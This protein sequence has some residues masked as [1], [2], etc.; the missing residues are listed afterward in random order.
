MPVAD[1]VS[2]AERAGVASST[3]GI[4]YS[5]SGSAYVAEGLQSARSSLKHNALPHVLFSSED[6][7]SVD[8]VAIKR[9]QASTEPF[10]DKIA[11]MRRSPFYRTIFLDSD[12]FVTAEIGHVLRLLDHYDIAVAYAP[13]RPLSDPEVPAAFYEFNTGVVA[14][15]ASDRVRVFLRAWEETYRAWLKRE[16]FPGASQATR[17]GRADQPAFR[18]CAWQHD[19]RLFVLPSEYNLRL[20]FPA[21]VSELVRVIHGR[22]DNYQALAAQINDEHRL[23]TWPPPPPPGL[24][25]KILRRAGLAF[26]RCRRLPSRRRRPECSGSSPHSPAGLPLGPPS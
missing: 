8:G 21:T 6:A 1:P 17:G 2:Q 7:P 11:N 25:R 26:G 12:T 19:L 9:F 20:G 16:P 23:R 22:H 18:R 3:D 13:Y 24:R 4:I 10:A 15:Q 5:Y 14:W